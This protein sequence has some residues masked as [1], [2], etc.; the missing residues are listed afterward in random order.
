MTQDQKRLAELALGRLVLVSNLPRQLERL[1]PQVENLAQALSAVE[2]LMAQIETAEMEKISVNLSVSEARVSLAL[3][4]LEDSVTEM[5]AAVLRAGQEA[6]DQV[7]P[8]RESV[9]KRLRESRRR[10]AQQEVDES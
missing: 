10:E 1:L 3:E 7:L 2:R 9:V 4:E 5:A 8:D 6:W